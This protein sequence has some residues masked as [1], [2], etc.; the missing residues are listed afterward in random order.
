MFALM[1]DNKSLPTNGFAAN[2]AAQG[3]WN[4]YLQQQQRERLL[5]QMNPSL[6]LGF[7]QGERS[8]TVAGR[9]YLDMD[10]ATSLHSSS[11]TGLN[12]FH[13]LVY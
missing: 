6:A 2:A 7:P 9:Q 13:T 12:G 10:R 3:L 5:N 8:A 1:S 11:L 4:P